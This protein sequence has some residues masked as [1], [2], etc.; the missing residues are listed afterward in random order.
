MDTT[1]WQFYAIV[2]TMFVNIGIFIMF[3]ILLYNGIPIKEDPRMR[4]T[5]NN[6]MTTRDDGYSSDFSVA[7]Q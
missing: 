3:V 1:L 4:M 7:S 5:K 2:T 6:V